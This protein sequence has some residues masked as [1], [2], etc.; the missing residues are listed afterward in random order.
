MMVYI[1][2][3]ELDAVVEQVACL[4][5][6]GTDKQGLKTFARVRD[7]QPIRD[8][9]INALALAISVPCAERDEREPT[10]DATHG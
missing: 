3:R 6:T 2:K 1:N 7:F 9:I 4:A 8:A 5:I 10:S